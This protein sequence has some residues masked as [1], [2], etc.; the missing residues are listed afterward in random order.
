[1]NSISE[2]VRRSIRESGLS[3]YRLAGLMR[4]SQ[5]LV[6]AFIHGR[7]GLSIPMLD[8]LGEVLRLEVVMHGPT[9][10]TMARALRAKR[11]K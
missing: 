8:R 11:R 7:R 5:A 10:A 6:S 3:Q 2:Q 1:V 9:P 4:C